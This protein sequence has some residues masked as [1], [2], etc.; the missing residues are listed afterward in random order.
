MLATGFHSAKLALH[1]SSEGKRV[2]SPLARRP[3]VWSGGTGRRPFFERQRPGAAVNPRFNPLQTIIVIVQTLV[4]VGVVGLV[5]AWTGGPHHWLSLQTLFLIGALAAALGVASALWKRVWTTWLVAAVLTGIGLLSLAVMTRTRAGWDAWV[6]VALLLSSAA[7]LSFALRPRVRAA[8]LAAPAVVMVCLWY[9][10][11]WQLGFVGGGGGGLASVAARTGLVQLAF[12]VVAAVG[13]ALLSQGDGRWLR[14][15]TAFDRSVALSRFLPLLLVLPIVAAVL[16]ALAAR[17]GALTAGAAL[18]LNAELNSIAIVLIGLTALRGLW[19]ERRRR[20]TLSR[21]V[22]ASPVIIHSDQGLIEFWHRGCEALFGY[23]AQEMLGRSA[24]DVLSPHYPIP[25]AEI[26]RIVRD[27]GE[28]SGEVRR[29]ARDGRR[30]WIATRIALDRPEPD[31]ELKLVETMTDITDLKLTNIALQDTTENLQQVATG[32]GVGLVDYRPRGGRS[33]FAP[34]MEY[35][36]GL[37][38]GGLGSD[39]SVW[40]SLL[41]PVDVERFT[42]AILDDGRRK[43]AGRILTMKIMHHD[44]RYRDLQGVLRYE[45]DPEGI[46]TRI[47]GAYMDITDAVRDR[48]EMDARGARLVELQTELAHTSRLSAMGELAA[49]LAH[50]LNQPLAAVGNSAGAIELMLRDDSTLVDAS[51]RQR[52][53]RAAHHAETQAVR[54]GEIVRR[55][56]EFIA[57][58]EA[59]S[60]VEDMTALVDDALALALPNSTANGVEVVRSIAPGASAVLADRIQVQQ[61]LVNLIRNAVEA[62]LGVERPRLLRITAEAR[63]GMALVRVIDNGAGVSVERLG[64]LF[65]PFLSTKRQGMGVGLFVSRHIIES[66]GGQLWFEPIEAHGAEFCFTLPLAAVQA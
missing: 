17:Q 12:L 62:M 21:A 37:E 53:R 66:H 20:S 24:A 48:M 26:M 27:M 65:S 18:V 46:M 36:L 9:G 30:L 16:F 57:R 3:V 15:L 2:H 38:S 4:P 49:A 8:A 39:Q 23:S 11:L 14:A 34:Q 55:L 6:M 7:S 35:M 5:L 60:R 22:E 64:T 47:A 13:W 10:A 51:L 29:T 41:H 1:N 56:R 61:V 63:E 42:Q 52:L 50:E 44:G 59:D 33:R 28:W 54:A 31:S 45:Y 58:G 32:Y 19:Q 43:A 25:Y 40:F